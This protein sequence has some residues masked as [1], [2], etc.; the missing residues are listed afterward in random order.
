MYAFVLRA[1][2]KIDRV[3][4]RHLRQLTPRVVTFPSTQSILHFEGNNGPDA[5]KFKRAIDEQPWHFVDP[6]DEN[7]TSLH[8]TIGLHYDALVAALRSQNQERAAFEAAWLAH[9]LVDGL[10][11]AHHY[12]YEEELERLRGQDRHSRASLR[13]RA[14]VYGET[15]GDSIKRSYQLVGPQGLLT[16]H[17]V[18]EA[19]AYM[20][21]APSR[22]KRGLPQSADIATLQ[23]LGV[24]GYFRQQA[25]E[26]GALGMFDSFRQTGW[27]PKLARMVRSELAPRMVKMVT[28]A[29]YAAMVDAGIVKLTKAR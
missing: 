14:L 9:A 5:P 29:W 18:F 10:T 28:L 8:E 11:P 15:P 22:I 27:T 17:A 6:F 3:A 16:T 7:D 2:Q 4:Y 13:D 21:L 20:A 26:V 1:H 25:K 12:P 19:G 23:Q 24:I